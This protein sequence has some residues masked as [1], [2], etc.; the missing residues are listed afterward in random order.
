MQAQLAAVL[1]RPKDG[2]VAAG[3][4][5]PLFRGR[6]QV[7]QPL[8]TLGNGYWRK[9]DVARALNASERTVE[10]WMQREELPHMKPFGPRGPVRFDPRKVLAWWDARCAS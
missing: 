4:V 10:R 2:A 3:K 9:P 8:V 1:E 5:I 7:E 6:Q